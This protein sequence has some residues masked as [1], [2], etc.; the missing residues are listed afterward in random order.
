[1]T[2]DRPGGTAAPAARRPRRGG[3]TGAGWSLLAGGAVVLAGG[4]ALGYPALA[5]LGVAAAGALLVAGAWSLVPPQLTVTRDVDPDRVTV[6]ERALAR[7]EISNDSRLPAPAFDVVE[8]VDGSPLRVPVAAL[9]ARA[10]RVLRYPIDASYRGLVKLGPVM[11][12]R[13]DPLGLLRRSASL[14]GVTQLWVHARVHQLRPLPIGVVLDFEG[15]LTDSAPR[16]SMAFASLRE[17][18]PGD[19]PRQIHWRSTARAGTLVVRERVDT[20]EPSVA[21]LL[22]TRTGMLDG[23]AFEDAV[24]VAASVVVASRRVGH[25]VT[26]GAPGE[27]RGAVADAGGFDVLDRLAAV[28]QT[29]TGDTATLVRLAQRAPGGGALVVVSGADSGLVAALAGQRR[30][31][32]R[33]VLVVIGGRRGDRALR[34]PGLAVVHGQTAVDAVRV[35]NRMVSAP[36]APGGAG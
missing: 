21:L 13:R 22:D 29:D 14:T 11:L 5:G 31:F 10:R 33:V 2:D 26:L 7:L 18:E 20:S 3:L 25:A 34:R 4:L 30:R 12:E 32:G 17:Y 1:M 27:D 19:D 35:W 15:R 28:R 36:E 24:E 6:G 16:G 9:G 8:R 23:A